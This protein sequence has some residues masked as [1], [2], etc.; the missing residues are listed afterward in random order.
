[1]YEIYI[2]AACILPVILVHFNIDLLRI[3]GQRNFNDFIQNLTDNDHAP[4]WER[5]Y[6]A[7]WARVHNLQVMNSW[8]GEAKRFGIYYKY[9]HSIRLESLIYLSYINYYWPFVLLKLVI[10]MHC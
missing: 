7:V 1:M 10:H 5:I 8:Y 3:H 9:D 2:S 6:G 4:W